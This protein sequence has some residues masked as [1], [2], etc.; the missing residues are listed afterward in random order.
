LLNLTPDFGLFS[1]LKAQIL[2]I[3]S[4][5]QESA[6]LYYI[7]DFSK[8]LYY[9]PKMACR[10]NVIIV[11]LNL[12]EDMIKYGRKCVAVKRTVSE[13]RTL[14]YTILCQI[15]HRNG[16]VSRTFEIVRIENREIRSSCLI[17]RVLSRTIL[18]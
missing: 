12:Q 4:S 16:P 17:S 1:N 3:C 7:I 5:A 2:D 8:D 10:K 13:R 18:S 6:N 11:L 9:R 15:Y 14:D